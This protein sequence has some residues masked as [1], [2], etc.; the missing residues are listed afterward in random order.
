MESMPYLKILC[1]MLNGVALA[2]FAYLT[3]QLRRVKPDDLAWRGLVKLVSLNEKPAEFLKAY[4]VWFMSFVIFYLITC[5]TVS[6]F[7]WATDHSFLVVLFPLLFYYFFA[8]YL[9]WEKQDLAD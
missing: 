5:L 1:V 2:A 9:L 8:R 3:L 7:V 4:R 6:I